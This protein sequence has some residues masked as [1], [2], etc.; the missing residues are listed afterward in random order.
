MIDHYTRR[1]PA[2]SRLHWSGWF[3]D[4]GLSRAPRVIRDEFFGQQ[5]PRPR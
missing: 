3:F 5:G 1:C 4:L 2:E